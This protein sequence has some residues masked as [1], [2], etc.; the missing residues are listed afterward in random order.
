MRVTC[1]IINPESLPESL[2]SSLIPY[3]QC[4]ERVNLDSHSQSIV[5]G[6]QREKAKMERSGQP[7][8][9]EGGEA[10]ETRETSEVI[11]SCVPP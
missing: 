7:G 2:S 6:L 8:S 1:F 10:L 11:R 5:H 9:R 3:L 4:K